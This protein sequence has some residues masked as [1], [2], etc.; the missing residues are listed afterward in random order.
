MLRDDDGC[1]GI[2]ILEGTGADLFDLIRNYHFPAGACIA[3]EHT[4]CINAKCIRPLFR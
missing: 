4:A 3:G 1:N 2:I